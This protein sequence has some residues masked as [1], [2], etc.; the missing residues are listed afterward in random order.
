MP[1]YSPLKGF[2]SKETGGIVFKRSKEAGAAMEV[3]CGQCLGCRLDRTRMWATR[4]C[5]ESSL[6]D[7]D[8]GNSFITLTYDDD[9]LPPDGGLR[10]SDFQ[11]FMKRLRKFFPQK[12]RY[13]M[14]GEY[15]DQCVHG[16]EKCPYC[17]HL[18]RPHYHA[19]LFNCWFQDLAL[20]KDAEGYYVYTSPTLEKLWGKG[21][22]TVGE[23]TYDSA[24]YVAS[25]CVKKITGRQADDWYIKLLRS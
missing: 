5:H 6:Y 20:Y 8:G 17:G 11:K 16:L 24:A 3:A 22:V 7:D 19:I 18:H 12:V 23:V 14:C 21:F 4:I 13:F 1:C 15:G 25:Y 9:H 2:K 10:K